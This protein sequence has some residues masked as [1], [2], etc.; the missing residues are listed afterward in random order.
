MLVHP[1]LCS[2][3][4]LLCFCDVMLANEPFIIH[5]FWNSCCKHC[6]M[7]LFIF[8]SKL[9]QCKRCLH[10]PLLISKNRKICISFIF[11]CLYVRCV[12][13]TSLKYSNLV[14]KF[15]NMMTR[16]RHLRNSYFFAFAKLNKNFNKHFCRHDETCKQHW[17]RNV[18]MKITLLWLLW[19]SVQCWLA[20]RWKNLH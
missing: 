15:F 9:E 16:H 18:R 10:V 12:L 6:C 14:W 1:N 13:C 8:Q 2:L 5:S 11:I 4:S 17:W 20:I 19:D 7:R 3:W